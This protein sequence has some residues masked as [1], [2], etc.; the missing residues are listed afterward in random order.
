[1]ALIHLPPVALI[2]QSRP[3]TSLMGCHT[4]SREPEGF[5]VCPRPAF[6]SPYLLSPQTLNRPGSY[7]PRFT[8]A[9][10]LRFSLIS[11]KDGTYLFCVF[12]VS[13]TP[14]CFMIFVQRRNHPLVLS[15][16]ISLIRISQTLPGFERFPSSGLIFICDFLFFFHPTVGP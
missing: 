13:S 4:T 15:Q 3:L 16:F 9:Q 11:K 12:S 5:T 2:P 1:L 6:A 14:I 7:N 10:H 8:S